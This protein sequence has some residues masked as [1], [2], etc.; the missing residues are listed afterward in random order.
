MTDFPYQDHIAGDFTA[1]GAEAHICTTQADPVAYIERAIKSGLPGA[2]LAWSESVAE[3][4]VR[5]ATIIARS[6]AAAKEFGGC[7][8][9]LA[10]YFRHEAQ[11]H[12]QAALAALAN[13]DHPPKIRMSMS[14]AE[15]YHVALADHRAEIRRSPHVLGSIEFALTSANSALREGYADVLRGRDLRVLAAELKEFDPRSK[16]QTHA[17]LV[18]R[19]VELRDHGAAA[20][21]RAAAPEPAPAPA[22]APARPSSTN[23]ALA[24]VARP[25]G[26]PRDVLGWR[27]WD[28][29][30]T[31]LEQGPAPGSRDEQLLRQVLDRFDD[32][33]LASYFLRADSI[34]RETSSR[35][36]ILRA[37]AAG[38]QALAAGGGMAHSHG[39]L[40]R[41]PP[42]S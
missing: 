37:L 34:A 29:M 22:P 4:E 6:T 27:R 25:S 30:Q 16:N 9:T 12:R 26:N 10:A 32:Q 7:N 35:D 20:V 17:A 14:A 13:P 15:R 21:R 38:R 5:A 28:H 33:A 18:A 40:H 42:I 41:S 11:P 31:L 19:L 8:K 3:T 2:I 24:D 36:E 23:H 39:G 1:A